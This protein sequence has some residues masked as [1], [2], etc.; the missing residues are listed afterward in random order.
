[1][2]NV[3]PCAASSNDAIEA[4]VRVRT[5]EL[6]ERNQALRRS[7]FYLS[8][9]QRLTHTGSWAFDARGFF[10]Y[11]SAE[12]FQI[13]GLD[14]AKGPPTLA[15]YLAVVHPQDREFMAGTVERVLRE[16]SGFDVKKRIIRPDGALRHIRCVGVPLFDK[17]GVFKGFVG[18]GMDVTD[19]EELT[20]QLRRREEY[21]AE[22]QRLSH[23]GSFGWS[24]ASGKILW[25][26]ETYRIFEYDRET[27]P[28][29][30]LVLARIHPDDKALVQELIDHAPQGQHFDVEYRL[31]FPNGTLKNVHVVAHAIK[32]E[33]GNVEFVGAVMDVTRARQAEQELR[34]QEKALRQS[35]AYLAEAQRLSHTGSWAWSPDTDV[36]YWSEECYRILG[37]D[38]RDGLPRIEELIQRIHPDYQAAFRESAR[39]ATHGKLDEEV[40]YRI[41]HPGGAARD[42]RSI[43][44]P[45]FSP[46]GELIEYTG[47]VIDI[48][49]R[50][51][52]E[53]TLRQSEAYLAEAQRLSQTGSWA[54]SPNPD[55]DIRYW[56]EECYRVL[57]FDP[58]GPLPR[59]EEFFQ[60][61][62]LDDQAGTRERF[63]K[64]IHDKADFELDYRIVHPDKGVR[65]IHVVGHAV[66]DP[67]GD[68]REFVG[69]VIDIT[70]RKRA[71]Q[72]LQ[73]LVDL[74]PQLIT[75]VAPDGKFIYANKVS[76]EYTGLTL[77]EFRSVD[78][79]GR[80][81]HPDDLEKVRAERKVGFSRIDPFEY[82]ARLLGKGGIYRWFLIRHNPLVE[83]GRVRRWYGTATEIE[84]RK[85]EEEQV[86]QEN[87]RLE[88]RTRIAQ[89]LHDTL[90]QSCCAA[91]M[92][93]GVAM[94]ALP[95]DSLLK[96]KIDS[97][98]QLMEQG[99]VEGRNAIQG[100][101]S[102]D[103]G[104]SDLVAALSGIQQELFVQPDVDFR[105]S[106]VGLQKPLRAPIRQEIYRIGK[107]ALVNAF[108]HSRAKRVQFELEYTDS[109]LSL[110]VRDNGC[111]IDPQVL[112]KG[113]EGHWGLAGMRERAARI[114]GL[115]KISSSAT[116]GTEIQVSI[117]SD[118]A[119][120]LSLPDL[121]KS[122]A[123]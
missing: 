119:F 56:S 62:H 26:D 36:R 65:D 116:E 15:Q 67:S 41:V 98:L 96:P 101:R 14:P 123:P 30:D 79:T 32:V 55:K 82:E 44:H 1:M 38:P 80:V 75:V 43:G 53:E 9:G 94:D 73:Q 61:I 2:K 50:K 72:D 46:S 8:E 59:F 28:T 69:T 18:T 111:G 5:E 57:G 109:N 7:Q 64:A 52:A 19:Q 97:I 86:R 40:D 10:D 114:G 89:E 60:R 3:N 24:V 68:L 84:S 85:Q 112:D 20:Q 77:E 83:E 113:S 105:V 34:Q 108:S 37:F 122:R 48:T 99:I 39:R 35:E 115:L 110:R 95:S 90:L 31:L 87:V 117:P 6:E 104:T 42:I 29:L 4:Q 93:L 45:V 102:S 92:K 71:E 66:L 25:S 81:V 74:V 58:S 23:T 47:T 49:E 13:F 11:W 78:V 63:E 12:L 22:A 91:T 88:E 70:E 51:R 21:L 16:E 17:V 107:E 33:L 76:R 121:G 27:E 120:Q 103:S 100:L 118:V 106:V 54:W